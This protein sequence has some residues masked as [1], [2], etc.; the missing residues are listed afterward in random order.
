MR[1]WSRFHYDLEKA[2]ALLAEAGWE[3]TDDD[4]ILDKEVDGVRIPFE[5]TFNIVAKPTHQMTAEVLKNLSRN[6]VSN[7]IQKAMEWGRIFLK[8]LQ[9]SSL[10]LSCWGWGTSP[11]V[12]FAQIWHS[13]DERQKTVIMSVFGVGR[14][15][16]HRSD[17]IRI[18]HGEALRSMSKRFHRLIYDEQ[19]YVPLSK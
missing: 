16:D 14:G 4:G 6:L 18:R 17:G 19:P 12:D 2:K 15:Q 3:D 7:A 11:N 10:G 5:F 8:E 1:L 13:S 9:S